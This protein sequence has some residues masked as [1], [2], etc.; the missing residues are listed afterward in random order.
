MKKCTACKAEK[1]FSAFS[2]NRRT[3]DGYGTCC[4]DCHRTYQKQ[5]QKRNQDKCRAYTGKYREKIGN[6]KVIE[7]ARIYREANRQK[8]R[9]AALRW[10]RDNPGKVNA[11]NAARYAAKLRATPGWANLDE[12]AKFYEEAE[13]L[14]KIHCVDYHVDHV[15]PLRSKLVCGLHCEANL[16]VIPAFENRSKG[17]RRWPDMP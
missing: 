17:N 16:E 5:W 9:D 2:R 1:D 12:I 7:A 13:K 15:V 11:A 4:K 6:D 10:Q 8:T 14:A 3:K